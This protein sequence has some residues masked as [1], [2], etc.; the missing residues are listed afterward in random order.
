MRRGGVDSDAQ[1]G[2]RGADQVRG[3]AHIAHVDRLVQQ[4]L[5]C[6]DQMR[7][8]GQGCRAVGGDFADVSVAVAEPINVPSENNWTSASE[9]SPLT[10]NWRVLPDV[11]SRSVSVSEP[12]LPGRNR[13][14][15]ECPWAWPD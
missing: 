10:S 5:F 3:G 7:P 13:R 11:L 4:G 1:V 6:G 9:V 8:V 2:G 12:L 14:R 15:V